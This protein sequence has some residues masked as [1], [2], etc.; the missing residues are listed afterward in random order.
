MRRHVNARQN[1]I[2][3]LLTC[4]YIRKLEKGLKKRRFYVIISRSQKNIKTFQKTLDENA[5]M[6]Y[7]IKVLNRVAHPT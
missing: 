6:C 4:K 5:L 3:I 2:Y 7:H 1:D